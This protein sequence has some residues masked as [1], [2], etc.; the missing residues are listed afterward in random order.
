LEIF[1]DPMNEWE[2]WWL[3][4]QKI[5]FR[6]DLESIRVRLLREGKTERMKD[7][8]GN[9]GKV[10][11]KRKKKKSSRPNEGNAAGVFRN[12]PTVWCVCVCVCVQYPRTCH[13]SCEM[14]IKLMCGQK[15]P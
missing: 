10:V 13:R 14:Q 12:F 11:L 8:G 15:V 5:E 4:Q 1:E 7:G 2:I 3:K 6:V 9:E